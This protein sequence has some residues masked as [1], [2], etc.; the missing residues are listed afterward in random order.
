MIPVALPAAA[1]DARAWT[2]LED[3]TF[4]VELAGCVRA[5]RPWTWGERERLVR[6]CARWG[7]LDRPAFVAALCDLLIDPPP[8]DDHERWA[9]IAL[10]LLDVRPGPTLIE[11]ERA[12]AERFGWTP[13]AID[14]E[15]AGHLDRLL[16]AAAPPSV[17]ADDGWT[18][19]VVADAGSEG[20]L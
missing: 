15:P 4:R 9:L 1:G 7:R 3:G 5:V 20:S 8:A 12:L 10:S 18:R 16:D 11:R 19:I 17:P 6:A 2:V 14:G 13:G